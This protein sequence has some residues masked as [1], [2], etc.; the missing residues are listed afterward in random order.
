MKNPLLLLLSLLFVIA[1]S[2]NGLEKDIEGRWEAYRVEH[3]GNF[4]PDSIWIQLNPDKTFHSHH[5]LADSIHE[6]SWSID[7][8]LLYLDSEL[9]DY[10]DTYWKIHFL[11]DTLLLSGAPYDTTQIFTMYLKRAK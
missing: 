9:G 11:G 1:C 4:A 5:N 6:G 8:E 3:S 7:G 2:N 10:Q